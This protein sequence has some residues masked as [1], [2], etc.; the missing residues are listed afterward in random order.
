VAVNRTD[1]ELL[2]ITAELHP[3]LRWTGKRQKN[4][5]YAPKRSTRNAMNG[6][7]LPGARRPRLCVDIL[8][9]AEAIS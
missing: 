6:G 7:A 2:E 9:D 4:I 3:D 5:G 8:R 1:L